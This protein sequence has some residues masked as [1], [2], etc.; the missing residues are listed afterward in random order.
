MLYPAVNGEKNIIRKL[1]ERE[2]KRKREEMKRRK[3]TRKKKRKRNKKKKKKKEKRKRKKKE[4]RKRKKKQT[5]KIIF[6]F[7]ITKSNINN[8]K[9]TI[10]RTPRSLIP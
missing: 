5:R 6:R 4:K 3:T 10:S 7:A 9:I 2:E 8:S 1:R